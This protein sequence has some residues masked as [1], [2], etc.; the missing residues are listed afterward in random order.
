M[1]LLSREVPGDLPRFAFR[2]MVGLRVQFNGD[3]AEFPISVTSEAGINSFLLLSPLW[4]L[5]LDIRGT[6]FPYW[7]QG[8][9]PGECP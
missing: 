3:A 2:V 5:F 7:A 4:S 6:H 9:P 1:L 8:S